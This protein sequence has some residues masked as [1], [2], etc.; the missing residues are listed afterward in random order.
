VWLTLDASHTTSDGS[1]EVV[2]IGENHVGSGGAA[3]GACCGDP[4]HPGCDPLSPRCGP[5]ATLLAVLYPFVCSIWF[6]RRPGSGE[7]ADVGA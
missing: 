5:W 3:E 2:A 4:H 1:D 7:L 6:E